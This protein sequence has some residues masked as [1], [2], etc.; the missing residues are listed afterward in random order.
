MA[1]ISPIKAVSC[2]SHC[3]Q[4]PILSHVRFEHHHTGIE[5]IRPTNVRDRR[6]RSVEVKEFIRR[7]KSNY[8]GIKVD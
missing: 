7:S 4:C 5:S 2:R 1:L 3:L 6:K 8:I